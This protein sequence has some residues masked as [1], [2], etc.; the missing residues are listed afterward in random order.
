MYVCITYIRTHITTCII[1]VDTDMFDTYNNAV[2]L[3]YILQRVVHINMS[4]HIYVI[5][6][7]V[8]TAFYGL[9]YAA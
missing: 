1:Y 3:I 9:Y 7:H 6:M 8:V 4:V 5:I 2:Y